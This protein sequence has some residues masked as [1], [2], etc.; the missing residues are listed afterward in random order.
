MYIAEENC[1]YY[2]HPHE[3]GGREL[4]LVVHPTKDCA[5]TTAEQATML[6]RLLSN[7]ASIRYRVGGR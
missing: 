7:D 1:V 2:C 6:A 4:F 5:K 3:E